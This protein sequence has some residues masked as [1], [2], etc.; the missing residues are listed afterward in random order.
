MKNKDQE[1]ITEAYLKIFLKE[2]ENIG[3]WKKQISNIKIVTA[4]FNSDLAYNTIIYGT[5]FS[6]L[7][8]V[9]FTI[10]DLF[11]YKGK[12]VSRLNWGAKLGLFQNIM[13]ND[14]CQV[15]YNNSFVVPS[16]ALNSVSHLYPK[17][18]GGVTL[19][20]TIAYGNY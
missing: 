9:F 16:S 19:L 6:H 20:E 10:E 14:I 13:D 3:D 12:D 17:I 11:Y 7:N 15:S 18:K 2:N 8:N 4:C 5:T 1:S